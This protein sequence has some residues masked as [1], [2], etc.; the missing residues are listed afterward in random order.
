MKVEPL[1]DEPAL[2]HLRR[3]MLVGGYRT[4]EA[5]SAAQFAELHLGAGGQKRHGL[6][7]YLAGGSGL[8]PREYAK[9]HSL[10]AVLN[11]VARLGHDYP[12]GDEPETE[13]R[14]RDG[15]RLPRSR[16]YVCPRC[17]DGDLRTRRFSWYRR[18]HQLIGVDWCPAHGVPL[19]QSL[20]ERSFDSLPHILRE[21]GLLS[22]PVVDAGPPTEGFT[23]RFLDIATGMLDRERPA[24]RENLHEV[25]CR[26]ATSLGITAT[27]T[28]GR[29]LLSDV[30]VELAEEGWLLRNVPSFHGKAQRIRFRQVDK[31]LGQDE[32]PGEGHSYALVLAT[33]YSSTADALE[34]FSGCGR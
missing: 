22:E 1:P 25:L 17:I 15:L 24:I 29:R 12:Y 26:K 4:E 18:V 9:R 7:H 33:L 23:R 8:S 34:A 19:V 13:E 6:L 28:G 27:G 11:P 10:L 30:I 2:A 32:S 16:A 3:W 5:F 31:L 14:E 21:S 20:E